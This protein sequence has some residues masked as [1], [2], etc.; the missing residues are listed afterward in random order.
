MT[1][2]RRQESRLS[3]R[4]RNAKKQMVVQGGLTKSCEK[5]GSEKHRRKG[6][7]HHL[8]AEFA[9][10]HVYH[11]RNKSPVQVRYRMLGAGALG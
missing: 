8:S 5:T 2:Y 9:L 11:I 6:K 7:I 1:L 4:K 10:K 3:P